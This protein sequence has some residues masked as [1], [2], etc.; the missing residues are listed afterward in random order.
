MLNQVDIKLKLYRS[1]PAFSLLSGEASQ[2]YRIDIL[3]IFLLA[4]KVRVSPTVIY[5]HNEML[6]HT[7]AKYF[8]PKT[9]TRIQSISTGST[10]FNW[11][12]LFQGQ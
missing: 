5:G 6:Q 3:D 1:S 9:D 7:N 8:F 10:T 12:N 11:E 2:A 4:R